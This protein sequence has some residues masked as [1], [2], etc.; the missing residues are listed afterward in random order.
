MLRRAETEIA[1]RLGIPSDYLSPIGMHLLLTIGILC[2]EW[3]IVKLIF[4]DLSE[5]V[6]IA[7]LFAIVALFAAQPVEDDDADGWRE[8]SSPV[9]P[10]PLLP[11]IYP[12]NVCLIVNNVFAYAVFFSFSSLYS[13]QSWIGACG[14][15]ALRRPAS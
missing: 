12:R 8:D 6:V 7:I 11:P 4:I 13:S 1:E 3:G 10:V 2:F 9:Q 15:C 5:I 14:R